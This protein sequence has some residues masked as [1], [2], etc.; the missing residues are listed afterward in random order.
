ML[1]A[2]CRAS[3]DA[4][5]AVSLV[6][7]QSTICVALATDLHQLAELVVEVLGV[8]GGREFGTSSTHYQSW[9]GCW[10][11]I[12]LADDGPIL[13]AECETASK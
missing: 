12:S 7:N 13:R 8:V 9:F 10:M 11:T 4:R 1:E 3:V 2:D 5:Q 6:G